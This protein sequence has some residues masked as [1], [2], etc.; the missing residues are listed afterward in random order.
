MVNSALCHGGE[1]GGDLQLFF[2]FLFGGLKS[3]LLVAV[4][5]ERR[6]SCWRA[7]VLE[8]TEDLQLRPV[9]MKQQCKAALVLWIQ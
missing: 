6:H 3:R 7:N 8:Y 2:F 4:C 5:F 9:H 1:S